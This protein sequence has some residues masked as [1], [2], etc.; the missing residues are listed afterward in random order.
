MVGDMCVTGSLPTINSRLTVTTYVVWCLKELKFTSLPT[1]STVIRCI[2]L[3]RRCSS[4]SDAEKINRDA[5]I[6]FSYG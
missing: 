5:F 6:P 1:L 4:R 3:T 2:S